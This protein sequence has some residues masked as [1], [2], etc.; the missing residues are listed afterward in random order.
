MR[1]VVGF[2]ASGA[3]RILLVRAQV[4]SYII[5]YFGLDINMIIRRYGSEAVIDRLQCIFSRASQDRTGRPG[6][7]RR[8][9]QPREGTA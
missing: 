3:V 6:P 1:V 4:T 8:D 2:R 5:I 9:A 7:T